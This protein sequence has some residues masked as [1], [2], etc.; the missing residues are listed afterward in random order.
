MRRHGHG[1]VLPHLLVGCDI[2][3]LPRVAQAFFVKGITQRRAFILVRRF[4]DLHN[5]WSFRNLG[6]LYGG[7]GRGDQR[8]ANSEDNWRDGFSY[9]VEGQFH[10]VTITLLYRIHNQ[11]YI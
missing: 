7:S 8:L 9:K 11:I 10:I 2:A 6:R 3:F 5:G 1:L 4:Y